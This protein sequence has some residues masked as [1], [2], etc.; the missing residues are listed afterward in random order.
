MLLFY[1]HPCLNKIGNRSINL[2]L[3]LLNTGCKRRILVENIDQRVV[4]GAEV[5]QGSKIDVGRVKQNVEHLCR[6]FVAGI[7]FLVY[8]IQDHM[9][10][11]GQPHGNNEPV[12]R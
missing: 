3:V 9:R 6:A 11:G 8:C 5:I 2:T 7:L 4:D 1:R 12:P 10:Q